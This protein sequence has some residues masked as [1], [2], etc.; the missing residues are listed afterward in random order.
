MRLKFRRDIDRQFPPVEYRIDGT[1]RIVLTRAVRTSTDEPDTYC[2]TARDALRDGLFRTHGGTV[3]VSA[4]LEA[5]PA[6]AIGVVDDTSTDGL[7]GRR[8][9]PGTPEYYDGEHVV[10]L[11]PHTGDVLSSVTPD[12]IMELRGDA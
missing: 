12:Q 9:A 3:V 11:D 2:V 8:Y 1:D 7:V 10:R 4:Y 6:I 5:D